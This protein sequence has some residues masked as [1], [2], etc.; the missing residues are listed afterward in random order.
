MSY[1]I[2]TRKEGICLGKTEIN[3]LTFVCLF[4]PLALPERALD[5][6]VFIILM[7]SSYLSYLFS[8]AKSSGSFKLFKQ[9]FKYLLKIQSN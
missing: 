9:L 5:D 8:C 7:A 3:C 2:P 6:S 1:F 4:V